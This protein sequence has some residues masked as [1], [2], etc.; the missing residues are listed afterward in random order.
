MYAHISDDVPNS[1]TL[2][3]YFVAGCRAVL[4]RRDQLLVMCKGDDTI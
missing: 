3:F 1:S 2:I 4:K